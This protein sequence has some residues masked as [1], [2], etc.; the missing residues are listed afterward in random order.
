MFKPH[1]F[2][3]LLAEFFRGHHAELVAAVASY[4]HLDADDAEEVAARAWLDL[5]SGRRFRLLIVFWPVTLRRPSDSN[6]PH[7]LHV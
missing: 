5:S 4:F 1:S 3:R 7:T 2:D 6:L